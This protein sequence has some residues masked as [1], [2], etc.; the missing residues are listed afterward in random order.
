M[1]RQTLE[2]IPLEHFRFNLI[3]KTLFKLLGW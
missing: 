2:S 3:E 1:S